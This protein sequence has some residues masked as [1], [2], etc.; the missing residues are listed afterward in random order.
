MDVTEK[1]EEYID[2]F[3]VETSVRKLGEYYE[4]SVPF[5][6]K[7]NDYIQFYMKFQNTE[8]LFT[9][10]GETIN[11]LKMDGSFCNE[12]KQQNIN[13]ILQQHH[14]YLAED[15]FQLSVAVDKFVIGMHEFLQCMIEILNI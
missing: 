13:T 6:D 12:E 7:N 14:V 2:W 10:G 15:E 11:A 8:I 9:D 1:L 5:L 3:K 4:I